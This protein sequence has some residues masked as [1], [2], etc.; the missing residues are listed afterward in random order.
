MKIEKSFGPLKGYI[1]RVDMSTKSNPKNKVEQEKLNGGRDGATAPP[2]GTEASRLVLPATSVPLSD[3]S[4]GKARSAVWTIFNYDGFVDA[5]RSEA[6]S[7][8]Y[9]VFG[10]EVCPTTGRRHLQG[11]ISW[12]NAQSLSAFSKRYGKCHIEPARGTAS[13][14]RVYCTKS[15]DFEEFGEMPS[16]GRRTDWIKVRDELK[17]KPVVD[18]LEEAPH[19]M[20][21]IRALREYKNMLLKPLHREVNV[22]VLIGTAGTGKTRYA[23]EK[24]PDIYSKP[25]GDWWDGYS[26]QKEILLDDYY[27]YLPYCELL[28]VLDRYPYQV[29]V[30][31]GFVQA[32]WDTVVITSNKPP[33]QW[34]RD[35]LTPALRRRL[36]NVFLVDSIDGVSSLSPFSFE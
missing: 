30:K 11:Y 35:G 23:Y 2:S 18:V 21:N 28:R 36:K 5:L 17:T 13:E 32:Q 10:K 26:G 19:L 3:D 6:Q 15:G 12:T 24:Y 34:Y 14:N 22:V 7:A 9:C 1:V 27:G 33:A 8:K 25:R 4:L 29:P 31:G 20:V 16:Q